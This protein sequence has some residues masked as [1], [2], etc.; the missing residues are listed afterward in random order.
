MFK[1]S[2]SSSFPRK[3]RPKY[4]SEARQE[5]YK[6]TEG[7]DREVKNLTYTLTLTK[8]KVD[9]MDKKLNDLENEVKEINNNLKAILDLLSKRE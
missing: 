1:A 2:S 7:I 5:H 9:G 6:M 3:Q 8:R 4:E